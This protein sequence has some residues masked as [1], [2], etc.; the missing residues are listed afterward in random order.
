MMKYKIGQIFLGY[1]VITEIFQHTKQYSFG[2]QIIH[3]K[4]LNDY[5]KKGLVK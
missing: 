1:G 3:E 5:E 2:G 4:V